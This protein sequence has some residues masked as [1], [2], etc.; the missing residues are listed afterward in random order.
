M[1]EVYP[2]RPVVSIRT[3]PGLLGEA[4]AEMRFYTLMIGIFSVMALALATLGIHGVTSYDATRRSHEFGVRAALG[5]GKRRL[6][7]L[8]MGSALRIASVGLVLGLAGALAATRMISAFLYGVSPHDPLTLVV[9]SALFLLAALSACWP[10][11][12]RASR[13]DILAMLRED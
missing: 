10:L 2:N 5:A 8:V 9:V 13:F 7:G 6:F 3:G 12:R 11:A 4:M 1:A